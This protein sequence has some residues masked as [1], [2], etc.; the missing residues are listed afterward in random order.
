MARSKEQPLSN[1][2]KS[3]K[4]ANIAGVG[5]GTLLVVLAKNIPDSY[6][7][8]SWLVISAPSITIAIS[9][10]WQFIAKKI[11][12]Y[13]KNKQIKKTTRALINEIDLLLNDPTVPECEKERL[14]G[15]MQEVKF[16]KVED[17]TKQL[18]SIRA[19]D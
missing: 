18:E 16:V 9:Y 3:P 10:L 8:K 17:L 15:K 12:Y 6:S 7:I 11:N 1:T 4:N 19:R 14:K 5:S 13:S 2:R